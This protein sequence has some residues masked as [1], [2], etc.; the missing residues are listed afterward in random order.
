MIVHYDQPDELIQTQIYLYNTNGQVIW[1]QE[2]GNPDQ[3]SIQLS[4]M[5]L[6]PGVYFYSV[7]IKSEGSKYAKSSGKII[8]VK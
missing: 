5:G 7:R 4:Q 3:V 8:V 2:Q 1:K 6:Q